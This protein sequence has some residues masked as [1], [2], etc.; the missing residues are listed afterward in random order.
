[1]KMHFNKYVYHFG[2][3]EIIHF[4][5]KPFVTV[6]DFFIAFVSIF[7]RSFGLGMIHLFSPPFAILL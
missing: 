4:I 5:G 6:G 2:T 3:S 1:M 7:C